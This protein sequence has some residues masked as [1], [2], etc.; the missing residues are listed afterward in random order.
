[1]QGERLLYHVWLSPACRKIILALAEKRLD[2]S[3]VVEKVWER[4]SDFYALNP[5]GEVPVL[6]DVD[7]TVVADCYAITEYLEEQ[8][9]DYPLMGR[10]P[11]A[12]AETRRL[13]AWFDHKFNQEVTRNLLYEKVYKR[14]YGR[15]NPNSAAMR[16]A[17]I[18]IHYHLE[19]IGFLTERRNWLAGETMTMADLSAA[20]HLSALDYLGNVPW[21]QHPHAKEWYMRLKS[22]PSFKLIL[23]ERMPAMQPSLHYENLDF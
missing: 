20:S 17:S 15:G 4:R 19:Y 1:M 8:Y 22:R 9:D 12:K 16:A 3:P 7:G 18:N 10:T 23:A 21:E 2:W 13:M 11:A 5:A 14:L 6:V